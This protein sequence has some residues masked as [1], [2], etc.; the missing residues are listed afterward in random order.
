[1]ALCP[2]GIGLATRTALRG[3]ILL[4]PIFT[5]IWVLWQEPEVPILNV[6]I[7]VVGFDQMGRDLPDVLSLGVQRGV[8]KVVHIDLED[9]LAVVLADNADLVENLKDAVHY[10]PMGA[11]YQLPLLQ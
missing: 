2:L 5:S 8:A 1:M 6:N 7:P 9:Q 3:S 4:E 11:V 10:P